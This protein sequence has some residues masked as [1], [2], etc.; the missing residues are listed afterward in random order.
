MVIARAG[1]MALWLSTGSC[2]GP[3]FGCQHPHGDLKPSIAPVPRDPTCFSGLHK[4]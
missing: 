2:K 4:H 3:K 1:E